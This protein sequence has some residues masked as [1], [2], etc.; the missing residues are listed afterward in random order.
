MDR[1]TRKGTPKTER[2]KTS[3]LQFLTE[4]PEA[5]RVRQKGKRGDRT[6]HHFKGQRRGRRKKLPRPK[7]GSYTLTV[8]GGQKKK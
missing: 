1:R 8:K 5:K 2:R 7:A 6:K 4:K 3:T